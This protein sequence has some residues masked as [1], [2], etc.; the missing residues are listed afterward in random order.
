M[1]AKSALL[2][3]SLVTSLLVSPTAAFN[4]AL[5]RIGTGLLEW[6]HDFANVATCAMRRFV[7]II[8]KTKYCAIFAWIAF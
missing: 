3:F 7:A 2:P 6:R 1:A 4:A 5:R 8:D